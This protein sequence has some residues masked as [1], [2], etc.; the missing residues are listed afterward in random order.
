VAVL[1]HDATLHARVV[2]HVPGHNSTGW[3]GDCPRHAVGASG[4]GP[5]NAAAPAR[6]AAAGGGAGGERPLV[7]VVAAASRSCAPV[8]GIR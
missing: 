4:G 5:A 8:A 7:G 2:H 1:L 3:L 6:V